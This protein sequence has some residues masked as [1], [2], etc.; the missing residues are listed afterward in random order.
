MGRALPWWQRSPHVG[1]IGPRRRGGSPLAQPR[2]AG[3]GHDLGACQRRRSRCRTARRCPP[4][5][6]ARGR[7]RCPCHRQPPVVHHARDTVAAR[8]PRVRTASVRVA[9]PAGRGAAR[10]RRLVDGRRGAMRAPAPARIIVQARL[11]D[12]PGTRRLPVQS[13]H[14]YGA[15]GSGRASWSTRWRSPAAHA[16]H[17]M[18]IRPR[19][20]SPSPTRSGT[21]RRTHAVHEPAAAPAARRAPGASRDARPAAL[22]IDPTVR[23]QAGQDVV[24]FKL[25]C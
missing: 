4:T 18:S 17:S 11:V 25:L 21:R 8:A 24:K 22:P 9:A 10:Q 2:C 1:R 3:R 7:C 23:A 16:S 14:R 6:T 20:T 5:P 19:R 15:C 13:K 12:G